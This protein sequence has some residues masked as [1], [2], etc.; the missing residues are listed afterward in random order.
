[1]T[2]AITVKMVNLATAI[3]PEAGREG[4]KRPQQRDQP[5]E[6][7][8]GFAPAGEPGLRPI[9][10]LVGQEDVLADLVDEGSATEAADAVAGSRAQHLT[11]RRHHNDNG[12]IERLPLPRDL[13]AGQDTPVDEGE[14][15]AHRQPH[16]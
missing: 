6:Q 10:I 13:A 8:D 5:P 3:S 15:G 7:H 1:M 14:L 2:Q 16:G 11:E 4:D 9:E 12:E